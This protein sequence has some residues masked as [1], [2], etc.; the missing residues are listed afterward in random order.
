MDKSFSVANGFV[1][2]NKYNFSKITLRI[3]G[4]LDFRKQM[5]LRKPRVTLVVMKIK[6]GCYLHGRRIVDNLE[7]LMLLTYVKSLNMTFPCVF[8][9]CVVCFI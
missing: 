9:Q 1:R 3:L 8:S 2:Y 4:N 5:H 6:D 7:L